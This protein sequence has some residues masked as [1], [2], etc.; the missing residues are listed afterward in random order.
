[1]VYKDNKLMV[2]RQEQ[3]VIG[4]AQIGL[5]G[6]L[7]YFSSK[8][9]KKGAWGKTTGNIVNI[10]GLSEIAAG[11]MNVGSAAVRTYTEK[12]TSREYWESRGYKVY[13]EE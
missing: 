12:K 9:V 6:G 8:Q 10:I 3:A 2:T 1:M 13:D 7:M 11:V 4:A 5:G